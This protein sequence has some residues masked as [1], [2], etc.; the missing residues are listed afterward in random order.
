MQRSPESLLAAVRYFLSPNK[1]DTSTRPCITQAFIHRSIRLT[2][3]LL[4]P[5]EAADLVVGPQVSLRVLLGDEEVRHGAQVRQ[6][7]PVAGAHGAV[8][9][10]NEPLAGAFAL[11][12]LREAA[13]HA[14][15]A[16]DCV[17]A[18]CPRPE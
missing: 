18:R 1:R 11:P 4:G 14:V 15:A 13:L 9:R 2:R 7:L 16:V 5:V 3:L 8:R 17:S 12:A 10:R 6:D